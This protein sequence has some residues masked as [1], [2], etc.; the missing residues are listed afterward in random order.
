MKGF[1][2]FLSETFEV[3]LVNRNFLSRVVMI[4]TVMKRMVEKKNYRDERFII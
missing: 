2:N 1:V 4:N 3:G